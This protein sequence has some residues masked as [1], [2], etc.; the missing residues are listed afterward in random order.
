M[1]ILKLLNQIFS[2]SQFPPDWS[3]FLIMLLPKKGKNI[4]RPITLALCLLNLMERMILLRLT[5]F[6]E[7]S[8]SMLSTQNGFRKVRSCSTSIATLISDIRRA[9]VADKTFCAFFVDIKSA[10]DHVNSNIL[11]EI[12]L[13]MRV[14]FNT[15]KF[16][17]NLMID[18][19]LYF[20]INHEIIG[21]FYKHIGVPQGCVLSPFLCTYT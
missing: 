17:F 2:T 21:T 6:L 19:K 13:E 12:I 11:Q 7:R 4:F 5:H 14:P 10:F 3:E 15:R 16:V 20:K 18:R 1:L 9:F 8:E